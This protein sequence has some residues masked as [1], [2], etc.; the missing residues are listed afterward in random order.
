MSTAYLHNVNGLLYIKLDG[1]LRKIINDDVCGRL[2]IESW[3]TIASVLKEPSKVIR[4]AAGLTFGRDLG[5]QAAVVKEFGESALYLLDED[6]GGRLWR[7][8]ILNAVADTLGFNPDNAQV[9]RLHHI[10]LGP[11]L[12]IE[13]HALNDAEAQQYLANYVDL[14][15]LF[16]SDIAKAKKHYNDYG[17]YENRFATPFVS[18]PVIDSPP[19]AVNALALNGADNFIDLPDHAWFDGS[20]TI[21]AWV[22]PRSF[23]NWSRI[24]DFG[25]GAPND[26]VFLALT[27]EGT[28][29]PQLSVVRGNA[30]QELVSKDALRLN[31]WSHVAATLNGTTATLYINGQ[32]VAQV[33]T[34]QPPN[35][36]V[37]TKNYLGRS[38]WG[39]DAYA[40]ILLSDVRIWSVARTA[41]QIRA[42]MHQQLQGAEAGLRGYWPLDELKERVVRNL[43]ATRL[44]GA[45][46][47]ATPL[48]FEAGN[49]ELDQ[50]AVSLSG[51]NGYLEIPADTWFN[52]NFTIEAWVYPRSFNY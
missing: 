30:F 4:G 39:S 7:R 23:N 40:N 6:N 37:R 44:D 34:M 42:Y 41:E 49:L 16:G 29:K 15:E 9:R 46:N 32:Q 19:A 22:Y 10:P 28:G 1:A 14:S 48:E 8:P 18:T 11:E 43:G 50:A 36:V 12:R 26:N 38:N 17:Y 27:R 52:G 33:T 2:C 21:E 13:K 31:T 20:F 5:L 35:N 25:N 47:G 3:L 24:L 51:N 45:L